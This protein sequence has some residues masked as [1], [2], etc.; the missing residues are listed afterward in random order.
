MAD[1]SMDKDHF[2]VRHFEA[3]K[4]SMRQDKDGVVLQ[5]RVHPNDVPMALHQDWV[6]CQYMVAMSLLDDTGKPEEGDPAGDEG[7]KMVARAGMLCREAA[8]YAFLREVARLDAD[9]YHQKFPEQF[10]E[11]RCSYLLR[12][13]LGHIE[14]RAHIAH[15]P[16]AQKKLAELMTRYKTW[17]DQRFNPENR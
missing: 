4:M 17:S 2:S 16:A 11:E 9:P 15:N 13:M 14:S 7:K 5:L 6:G 8:F 12:T 3:V 10:T 1:Q